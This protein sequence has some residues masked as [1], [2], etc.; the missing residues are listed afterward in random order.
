MQPL[1]LVSNDDNERNIALASQRILDDARAYSMENLLNGKPLDSAM[2]I[3]TECLETILG[4]CHCQVLLFDSNRP[5]FRVLHKSNGQHPRFVN[6]VIKYL[7]NNSKSDFKKDLKHG[8]QVIE[9]DVCASKSW[10]AMHIEAKELGIVANWFV[11]IVSE[12]GTIR[13]VFNALFNTT[14]NADAGELLLLRR[15]ANSVCALLAHSKNKTKDLQQKVA[16][17]K[18]YVVQKDIAEEVSSLLKKAI[19][20]RAEVQS[21]L[22]ELESMAALGTMMSS[23]THEISTPIGVSVTAAS[24]LEDMQKTCLEKVQDDQLKRSELINYLKESAEASQI[25]ERNMLRADGLI[26]TFKRLSIDQ[27]SQ[28]V[29]TF[30]LCEYVYEV[31]LSLKPR[32]KQTPHKFC[33]DIPADLSVNS[34]PGA[35]SQLLINLI[36]NSAHHAFAPDIE[37][38][39]TI[40]ANVEFDSIGNKKLVL[41]YRDNGKGMNTQ[42]IENMYKPFFTLARETEGCGLGMHICNNIVMKVLRGTIDCHSELGKGVKFTIVLPV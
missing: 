8:V 6:N 39:I 26:K 32:L 24:F 15:A 22:L 7:L 1:Q 28:D 41:I 40:K 42:T 4:S 11:P 34:N 19:E 17:H 29:R 13:G 27:H 2:K 14:R 21:Q 30:S 37:G 12:D 16:L 33:V 10:K 20:Q 25:I 36:M 18:K 35:L 38:Q 31:L 5:I 3:I 23:L 9:P